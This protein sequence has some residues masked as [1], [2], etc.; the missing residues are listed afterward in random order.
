MTHP[1]VE[2]HSTAREFVRD[3]VIGLADGLTVPF[4]LAAGLA[5][6]INSTVVIV[7]AGLAEIAAGS[8]AMGLG[9]YLAVRGD[10]EHYAA[11]RE[12]EAR[13]IREVPTE[14]AWEVEE[15]LGAYGVA[16]DEARPLINALRR[17]PIAWTDFMMRFELG[18]EVPQPRRALHSAITI[19]LSYVAG[20]L[21]PLLP[22]M[23]VPTARTALIVSVAITL[24]ALFVF[25]AMKSRLTG[26]PP[27]PG[28]AKT[29]MIGAIASAAAYLIARLIA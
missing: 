17:D 10:A 15:I 8:I 20:G 28:A 29:L 5:G 18:L 25:G 16:S 24:V 23:L 22:Y 1:H 13:E 11:E 7:T 26:V 3:A 2:R 14:E 21:L 19:G 12:R 4:A 9:G 27:L 6:A